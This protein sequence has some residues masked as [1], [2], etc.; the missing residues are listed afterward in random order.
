[1]RAFG[2]VLCGAGEEGRGGKGKRGLPSMTG[3]G[4]DLGWMEER[5]RRRGDRPSGEHK[6]SPVKGSRL[7]G[8]VGL[9]LT[10]S[11]QDGES[12]RDRVDNVVRREQ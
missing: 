11:G 8:R 7:S 3:L 6:N 5:E 2:A 1:M 10:E 4:L 9:S 12:D